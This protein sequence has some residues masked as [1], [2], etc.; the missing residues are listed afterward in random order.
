MAVLY[1]DEYGACLR[2]VD[3]L[4]SVE[5]DDNVLSKLRVQ[6]VEIVIVQNNCN[7]TSAAISLLLREGVPVSFLSPSG[8]YL[9][10]LDSPVNNNLPLRRAQY[11]L[12]ADAV[13]SLALARR[14]V[15]GKLA[16]MR[17]IMMRYARNGVNAITA[18]DIASMKLIART[19]G[20]ADDLGQLLG[21]EGAGTR[22]YFKA[23]AAI[24]PPAFG[25]NGRERRPPTDPANAMLSFC[26]AMLETSVEGALCATG[27]DP[28]CGFY[29][30]DRW[31]RQSLALDLMEEMRPVIADSVVLNSCIRRFVAPDKDFEERDGGVF[32]NESGREKLFRAFR[33]RLSTN[34]D[35]PDGAKHTYHR[36]MIAQAYMLAECI[37]N[38]D[39]KYQPFLV[40]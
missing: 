8:E 29:H 27:L 32:L 31:G 15:A 6:E 7:L 28:C 35:M 21:A 17:T 34:I 24:I 30:Q 23:L 13:F 20:G 4:L 37:K 11:S 16:N 14:F 3:G 19:A 18:N 36:A 10:R 22:L 9:G 25:F 5:K 12:S 33:S 26:Y 39:Y 38:K 40:K 1:L 2:V